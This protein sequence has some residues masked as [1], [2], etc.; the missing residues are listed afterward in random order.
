MKIIIT[1]SL[2]NTGKPL[3]A[4]L[5]GRGHSVV[6]I[7]SDSER[8]KDI[9]DI[10]ARAAVGSV[11]DASFLKSVFSE[12]DALFAMIP[13]DYSNPDQ[14][15]H[16]KQIAQ[17]YSDSIRGSNIR[18][19]VHL[20]SWGADLDRDTGFIMGSHFS[21]KILNAIHGVS[22]THL[23]AGFIYYNLF[24]FVEMIKNTGHIVANYGGK[25]KIVMV[26]PFDIA[27]AAAEE[28]VNQTA[29][30]K[31]R[32]VASDDRSASEVAHVLGAAIGKS[33][34]EWL[35]ISDEELK[36]QM[37]K[38]NASGH[39]IQNAIPL[40]ASIHN[41]AMRKD[42]DK[43]APHKMGDVKLETFAKRFADIYR[44]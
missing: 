29:A 32:Y 25:D 11:K 33:D 1:G 36:A 19:I 31:V 9:E 13:P 10:G 34:L 20:S 16:Y 2:G 44:K 15:G 18:R 38:H 23:R 39:I 30:S 26:D 37:E 43:T 12:A 42:Y 7:S 22:L 6:V 24:G 14:V 28:L 8:Q 27:A 21:E 41:G 4:N 17:C 5:I 40:G 3:A 35:R